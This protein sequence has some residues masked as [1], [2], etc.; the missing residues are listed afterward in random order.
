MPGHKK[1]K[2]NKNIEP[3]PLGPRGCLKKDKDGFYEA[4]AEHDEVMAAEFLMDHVGMWGTLVQMGMQ[5]REML[6]RYNKV[7]GHEQLVFNASHAAS[8]KLTPGSMER[9]Q[10]SVDSSLLYL[11]SRV[12]L[13]DK[14]FQEVADSLLQKVTYIVSQVKRVTDA[15]MGEHRTQNISVNS[16]LAQLQE[17]VAKQSDDITRLREQLIAVQSTL[18]KIEHKQYVVNL[19]QLRERT[20]SEGSSDSERRGR[21]EHRKEPSKGERSRSASTESVRA[22]LMERNIPAAIRMAQILAGQN[23]EQERTDAI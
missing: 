2:P 8:M 4:V 22:L 15:I 14:Y 12:D 9:L 20:I 21:G 6:V 16:A 10:A 11:G 13:M 3:N 1:K 23:R 18:H 7:R 5:H 19:Q 17:E